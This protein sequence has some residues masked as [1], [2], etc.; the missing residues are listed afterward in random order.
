MPSNA[1]TPVQMA[2]HEATQITAKLSPVPGAP[3][4]SKAGGCSAARFAALLKLRMYR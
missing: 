3:A 4:K 1:Q 2:G